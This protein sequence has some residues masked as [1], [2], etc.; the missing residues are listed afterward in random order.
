[1]KL[2]ILMHCSMCKNLQR[3]GGVGVPIR[4]KYCVLEGPPCFIAL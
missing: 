4:T 1:M 3:E 2:T